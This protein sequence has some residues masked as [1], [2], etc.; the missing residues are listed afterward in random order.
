[1]LC[2]TP[3]WH[4]SGY[5]E[6]LLA[7]TGASYVLAA[8]YENF[9]QPLDRPVRFINSLTDARMDAFLEIVERGTDQR[10]VLDLSQETCGPRGE[11]WIVPLPGEW[12][13]FDL[14]PQ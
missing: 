10:P 1:M 4:T 8:H 11:R 7:A 13:G 2:T 3:H 12:V 5:P 14:T 9:L 6:E